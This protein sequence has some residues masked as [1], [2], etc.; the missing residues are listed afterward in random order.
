MKLH[1]DLSAK[2]PSCQTSCMLSAKEMGQHSKCDMHKRSLHT[3]EL[4]WDVCNPQIVLTRTSTSLALAANN[5]N[6]KHQ[7][8]IKTGLPDDLIETVGEREI[9]IHISEFLPN[10]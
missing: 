8:N 3:S 6:S 1:A 4:Y 7:A 10:L 2:L 5:A 9:D